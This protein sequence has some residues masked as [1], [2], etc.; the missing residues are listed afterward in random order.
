M[1]N[2]QPLYDDPPE[3][4]EVKESTTADWATLSTLIIPAKAK[5]DEATVQCAVVD[6]DTKESV[7]SNN[8]TMKIQGIW[9][10][11][12]LK[13]VAYGIRALH[14]FCCWHLGFTYM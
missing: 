7:M 9:F 2:G 5:Y 14:V 3:D 4:I 12:E 10:I 1:L 11:L 8:A 6:P 13:G